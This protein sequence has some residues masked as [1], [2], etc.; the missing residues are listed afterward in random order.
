MPPGQFPHAANNL[1][2]RLHDGLVHRAADGQAVERLDRKESYFG[3]DGHAKRPSQFQYLEQ[4][5][6]V[7]K[8]AWNG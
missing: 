3:G 5:D 4:A 7:R 1:I 8:C 6:S 2:D